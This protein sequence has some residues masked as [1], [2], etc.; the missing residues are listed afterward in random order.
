MFSVPFVS[1]LF[2][3]SVWSTDETLL[4]KVNEGGKPDNVIVLQ[5]YKCFVSIRS[6]EWL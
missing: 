6:L 5:H 1:F 4:P 2:T 3:T